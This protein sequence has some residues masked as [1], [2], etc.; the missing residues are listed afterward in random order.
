[1][2]NLNNKHLLLFIGC[3]TNADANEN[4]VDSLFI[5]SGKILVEKIK[6]I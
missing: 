6:M 5:Q 1:M 3:L 2:Q 4:T